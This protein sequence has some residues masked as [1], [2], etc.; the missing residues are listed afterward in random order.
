MNMTG[1]QQKMFQELESQKGLKLAHDY[2]LSYVKQVFDRNVYPSESA[3]E[4]LAHFDE[5]LPRET[6]NPENI[7]NLLNTHGGPATVATSGSRYFGFVTGSALPITLASKSL[8]TVWDQAPAMHV[9]SP[10]GSKLETI[11]EDWLRK[12]FKLP[13]TTVAGFVS[14][15]SLAN[16]CGLAAARFHQ[17]SKLGWNV[18]EKGLNGSPRLRVVAGKQCHSTILKAISLLG[19]GVDHIEW[20]PA[21][22]QGRIIASEIPEL[23]ET[24]ILILQAGNVNT[25]SFDDFNA[26]CKSAQEKG[27]WIHI[28]GAFGLWAQATTNL[29][30][31]T[32]GMEHADSWAVDAHKTLNTPYDSGIVLCKN[33]EALKSALHMTGSYI[34]TSPQR[35]GMF[36]T[37]EMSRRSRIIELWA[38]LRYLGK[39]GV[40]QLVETM[41]HRAVQFKD[42]LEKIAGF[43]VLNDV[44]FNQVLVRCD[45]DEITEKVM[46]HVQDQRECWVGGSAW[47]NKRTIRISICSWATTA[48]D[49]SRSVDSFRKAIT[50][51]T[52][53]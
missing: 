47:D 1:L 28:D 22:D 14:G 3:L 53:E 12:L 33:P 13:E 49:I 25:G 26:I 27:A 36:Y 40:D 6:G 21:D 5:D 31:L 19:F 7:L 23:D 29:A 42:E 41:Y 15:T 17:L 9:T 52:N 16:F 24:S 2:A 51:V 34:I 10:I 35:D 37:P 20:V 38:A 46:A 39:T 18:N 4:N 32:K 48:S 45:T 11:V 8:S 30:H 43:H 50:T 44:V